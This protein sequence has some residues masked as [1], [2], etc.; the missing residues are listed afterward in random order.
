MS[1]RDAR[2]SQFRH[3]IDIVTRWSDNDVYG[4]VNNV[5]YYSYFDT[6]VNRFLI[7]NGVLDIRSDPVVGYV[8]ETGCTYFRPVSFP[9]DLHVGLRV[10][11]LGTS[12]VRYEVAL[13]RAGDDAP[14]AAG[15]FVHV[16]VD[17]RTGRSAPMP[18]T[19][20]RLLSTMVVPT[21]DATAVSP[22]PEAGRR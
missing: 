14:A 22:S 12:S 5:V 19:V 8:A 21:A 15:H 7:D 9:D 3:V 17:R 6:A 11:R 10:A 20:R 13:F 2:R 18:E 16:Y 1:L 4:H